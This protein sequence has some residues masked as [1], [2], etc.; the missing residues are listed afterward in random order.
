MALELAVCHAY[1]IPHSAFLKW[2]ADDRDKAIWQ[3]VRTQ[4][5]CS[6]CGTRPEEW[7]E[8]RGGDRHAYH[9]VEKRCRGCEEIQ[10]KQESLSGDGRGIYVGLKRFEGVE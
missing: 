5:T 7:D 8:S 3:Y 9:A 10:A 4:S 6:K 2:S 1:R